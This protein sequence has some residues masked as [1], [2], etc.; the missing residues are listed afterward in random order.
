MLTVLMAASMM[1]SQ[2]MLD[3]YEPQGFRTSLVVEIAAPVETV[4]DVATGDV[5]PWWDHSFR[6]EPAEL[7]IEPEFGGR[8]YERF[9]AGAPDGALHA[10]VIYVDRPTAL[11]LHGPLG[12]SGR[13]VDLVTSWTLTG[14]EAGH[15]QFQVEFSIQG[16][17]DEA[18]AG[19]VRDVWVHFIEDR[20]KPYVE[21]GCYLDPEAPCAAFAP[22]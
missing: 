17:V 4:F 11:R 22:D 7:V 16:E 21:A 10:R 6:L 14:D 3:A 19:V 18:L 1:M 15:T 12:L 2:D 5:S 20:L 8:F 9:E 13:A